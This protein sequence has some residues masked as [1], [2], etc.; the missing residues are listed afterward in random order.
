MKGRIGVVMLAG[1]LL[2][3][4]AS[5]Q[6]PRP[7]EERVAEVRTYAELLAASPGRTGLE[8]APTGA[9]L[10]MTLYMLLSRRRQK[11]ITNALYGWR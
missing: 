8:A 10:M 4:G 5:A 9:G 3:G 2:A 7:C 1:L 11:Q 6:A